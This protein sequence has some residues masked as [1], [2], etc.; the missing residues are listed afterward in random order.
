M[1]TE[2][3]KVCKKCGWVLAYQ[4]PSNICPICKT[5]FDI[6]ICKN[7]GG[8]MDPSTFRLSICRTCYSRSPQ[9]AYH[10]RKLKERRDKVFEEWV[11]KIKLVPKDYP[12]LT[13]EQWLE[14]VKYFGK[15]A[16]CE[17]ESVDAR[18]YF[19]PFQLGGRYCNWNVIP[20]CEKCV[21]K[22]K[23]NPNYFIQGQRPKGLINTI[24]YLEE[25]LNEAIAKV[26]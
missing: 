6:G 20:V 7:C 19:I 15:C 11:E 23:L 21:L 16:L 18:A 14:A 17:D 12:T 26:K 22:I 3:T 13:E 4:D 1:T 9:K 5:R 25:K 24:T 10:A 2:T 8:P